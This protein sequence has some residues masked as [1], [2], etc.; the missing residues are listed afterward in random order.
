MRFP[1]PIAPPIKNLPTDNDITHSRRKA[2]TGKVKAHLKE[3]ALINPLITIALPAI[4]TVLMAMVGLT[5]RWI[6]SRKAQ[7]RHGKRESP[8]W[9]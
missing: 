5:A 6:E 9:K 3:T 7:F 4:G 8:R 1:G 2:K